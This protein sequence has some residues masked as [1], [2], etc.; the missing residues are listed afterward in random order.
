[1]LARTLLDPVT[2]LAVLAVA[3][4]PWVL[5]RTRFGLRVRAA[6]ENPVAAASVGIPVVRVRLIALCVSGAVGALGGIH[7]AFDQHR[8]ESGMSG[9]RG[10]IALAAVILA[11][12]RP[13]R[14]ALACLVF[15]ALEATQILLQGQRKL[16]P[17][18]LQMLPYLATLV[19]LVLTAGKARAPAGL[20]QHATEER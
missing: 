11:G 6:G 12:W 17:E 20:G 14:A 5:F 2:L 8:F 7:L 16:P 15:A 18:I 10:F 4:T 19:V 1:M 13:V 3:V 9:G